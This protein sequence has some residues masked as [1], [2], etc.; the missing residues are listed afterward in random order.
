[1]V[2]GRL[3]TTTTRTPPTLSVAIPSVYSDAFLNDDKLVAIEVAHLPNPRLTKTAI[4][5]AISQA[6]EGTTVAVFTASPSNLIV[7]LER[8]LRRRPAKRLGGYSVGNGVI[9]V[10]AYGRTA[11]DRCSLGILVEAERATKDAFTALSAAGC[12]R[13]I[14]TGNFCERAHW[15][16]DLARTEGV[17][18]HRF[19]AKQVCDRWP[20]Q[21]EFLTDNARTMDLQDEVQENVRT[22]FGTFARRRLKIVTDKPV[23][24]LSPEQQVEA[25]GQGFPPMV[26]MYLSRLQRRYEA[27]K[28]LAVQRG[29]QPRFLLLKPRRGQFTT[30][31]QG[32]SYA[33]AVESPRTQVVTLAHTQSAT[34]RIFNMV[35]RFHQHDSEA[36]K[37]IGE[38]KSSLSFANGSQFFIGTAGSR[39]FSRGDTLTRFHG[40]EVAYWCAG[41]NSIA[42][43]QSLMSGITAAASYGEIVL[44]TTANGCEWFKAEYE[45]AK[46]GLNDWNAVFF[47]WWDDPLNQLPASAY[48]A[49]ELSDTLTEEE[50]SLITRFQLS[51]AQ[52]AWR[53][54]K[55]R[56]FKHLFPQEYPENDVECFLASG[57]AFFDVGTIMRLIKTVPSD[58]ERKPI[59]VASAEGEGASLGYRVTWE[60]PIKGEKYV[61]GCDTSEGLMGQDPNGVGI[62]HKRS[63]KQVASIHGIFKPRVLADLCVAICREYN[64]A[65]LGIERENHGHAVL[66]RVL[67]LEYSGKHLLHYFKDERPGW[68]TN[69]ETR[70]VMLDELSDALIANAI[71]VNDC[72]FLSECNSFRL[73]DNQKYAADPGAHDDTV[74]K[75]AVAWQMR[76][77]E[78]RGLSASVK[79]Y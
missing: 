18:L 60:A 59:R 78:P 20:D 21:F 1:M 10:V 50:K 58:Y 2:D 49:E 8:M 11:A 47:P 39:G 6:A 17:S 68:S 52:I 35:H 48:S 73:Q 33:K 62:L 29:R 38:S 30:Y 4:A 26:S 24:M 74:M 14:V 61:A 54:Q 22:P 72:D 63:G 19:T 57:T 79:N 56:E 23:S 3:M 53:R 65:Y 45:D 15:F 64:D 12:D 66:Q 13:R 31:E 51:F 27:I 16:Y 41:P 76:K 37:L 43:V 70:P 67:Q 69:A 40:S 34:Q 7:E 75:W 42:D 55:K 5:Y 77:L 44:E 32:R 9:H 28:R 36:L 71:I 46:R 25:E